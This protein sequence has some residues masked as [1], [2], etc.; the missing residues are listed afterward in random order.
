MLTLLYHNVLETAAPDLP[1]AGHQVTIDTFRAHLCRLRKNLLHPV[2]IHDDLVQGRIP[3]GVLIT[4]DDGAAGII[5]AGRILAEI[6]AV[7]VAFICPGAL[8]NGLWFYRLADSLARANIPHLIWRGINI[9]LTRS[10][11]RRE[12]YVVLNKKLSDLSPKNRDEELAEIISAL[13]VSES[14]PH[15]AL[16]T[17][18]PLLLQQA[19]DTGGLVFANHTWSHPNLDKLCFSEQR[20]EIEAAQTWLA[21]SGLPFLPWFAFPRGRYN[22]LVSNA[23]AEV[24]PV[25]FGA[26]AY[27]QGSVHPRTYIRQADINL[28]RFTLKTVWD[29]HLRRCM[30]V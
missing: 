29:G 16:T 10:R 2:E 18:D 7:G 30:R 9:H 25:A 22:A 4:F 17:L 20:F 6:G 12:A 24:C 23:V 1:V 8:I 26:S 27:D 19:A 21:S 5:E 14:E 28:I 3:K 15:P 13:S 11:E